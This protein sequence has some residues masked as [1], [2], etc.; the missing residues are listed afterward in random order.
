MGLLTVGAEA[1]FDSFS[2]FWEP[3]SH[4]RLPHQT[5]NLICHVWLI[6]MGGP[7]FSEKNLRGSG[8]GGQRGDM[9]MDLKE[10]YKGKEWSGC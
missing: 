5:F 7:P 9:G 2:S 6:F 3:T 1:V 8:W 4:T 10:R